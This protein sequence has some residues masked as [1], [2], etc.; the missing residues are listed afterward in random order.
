[1]FFAHRELNLMILYQGQGSCCWSLLT[2]IILFLQSPDMCK[3]CTRPFFW[4]SGGGVSV[5]AIVKCLEFKSIQE[6]SFGFGHQK[7]VFFF[8][9]FSS[10]PYMWVGCFPHLLIYCWFVD[11]VGFI[12]IYNLSAYWMPV[13]IAGCEGFTSPVIHWSSLGYDSTCNSL[14]FYFFCWYYPVPNVPYT[15]MEFSTSWLSLDCHFLHS[16]MGYHL[17]QNLW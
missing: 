5:S 10:S 11:F 8:L 2:I 15:L 3:V 16:L 4:L 12:Y 9:S 14:D 13:L 6:C 1:M 7:S 17:M